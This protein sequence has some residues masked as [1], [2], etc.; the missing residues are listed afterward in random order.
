MKRRKKDTETRNKK[1]KEKRK[2]KKERE[3]MENGRMMNEP[4]NGRT[5]SLMD[6]WMDASLNK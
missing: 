1:K 2:R 4:A 3:K 5:G 6:R